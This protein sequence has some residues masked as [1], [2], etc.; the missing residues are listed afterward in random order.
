[1]DSLVL[2]QA[3]APRLYVVRFTAADYSICTIRVNFK[4]SDF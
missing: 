2:D 1:M 4:L 3:Y